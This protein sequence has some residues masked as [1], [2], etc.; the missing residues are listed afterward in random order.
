MSANR[1]RIETK[2]VSEILNNILD[3]VS[4]KSSLTSWTEKIVYLFRYCIKNYLDYSPSASKAC[5][6]LQRI[7]DEHNNILITTTGKVIKTFFKYGFKCNVSI[8]RLM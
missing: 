7:F 3:F 8:L 6:N 4:H 2:L 1:N 5:F